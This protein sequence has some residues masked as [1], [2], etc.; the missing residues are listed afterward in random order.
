[1]KG[2]LL[3]ASFWFGVLL[4]VCTLDPCAGAIYLST[5][6]ANSVLRFTS[7]GNQ[8]TFA[9]A[10]SGLNY[11]AGLAFDD[12]NLYVANLLNIEEFGPSGTGAVFAAAG[13]AGPV[14]LAFDGNGNLFVANSG[15]NTIEEFDASGTGTVFATASSGIN[16]PQGL[17][18]DSSGN[19]YVADH[20]NT[21]LKFNPNGTG[22]V[23]ATSGV[24]NPQ[25]LAFDDDGNLFVANGGNNTIQ[26]FNTSGQGSVF[27]STN[28]V[29]SPIGLAFDSSG[30]LYVANHGR[31]DILEFS[32]N[33]V[34]TVFASG[35]ANAVGIAIDQIP[36]PSSLLLLGLGLGCCAFRLSRV[37]TGHRRHRR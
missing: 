10:S 34:G 37:A 20:N 15:N 12:G 13:V 7:D 14:A 8:S 17:A 23:F 28:L 31:N 30:D 3:T 2:T 21:I 1:M 29:V 35:L 26:E 16:G 5:Y 9:T 24:F 18:F 32:P 4:R 22:A 33:G 6:D 27:T 11:P 25:G 19:L 36:E